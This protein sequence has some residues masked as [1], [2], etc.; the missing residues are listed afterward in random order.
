MKIFNF[1]IFSETSKELKNI[2]FA[3][4]KYLFLFII[5]S[6]IS[7]LLEFYCVS[8]IFNELEILNSLKNIEPFSIILLWTN[9]VF[10]SISRIVSSKV[11]VISG[12]K[13]SSSYASSVVKDIIYKS[14]LWH[15]NRD[16]NIIINALTQQQS[17][18][19]ST[20]VRPV[21]QALLSLFSSIALIIAMFMKFGNR[22]ILFLFFIAVLYLLSLLSVRKRIEKYS[23]NQAGKEDK[24]MSII[25]DAMTSIRDIF[26]NDRRTQ[27]IKN[28]NLSTLEY[29]DL[30]GK[31]HFLSSLPKLLLDVIVLFGI[32]I[33]ISFS[34]ELNSILNFS[35]II[36][37][38]L[39]FQRLLPNIISLG[40]VFN[41]ISAGKGSLLAVSKLRNEA[42]YKDKILKNKIVHKH[43]KDYSSFLQWKKIK[44]S[45]YERC[46]TKKKYSKSLIN[47]Y[48][49]NGIS[50][51]SGSGKT[52]LVD[53][54][55]GL[56]PLNLSNEYN[57]S[58]TIDDVKQEKFIQKS[59]Y[60]NIYYITQDTYLERETIQESLINGLENKLDIKKIL[61]L[62]CLNKYTSSYKN[63]LTSDLSGG[64][65][66][67]LAIAKA[68]VSR[69]EIIVMDE[70]TNGLD[71]EIKK[72]ILNNLYYWKKENNLTYIV[73]SHDEDVLNWCD[74][75][76]CL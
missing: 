25:V 55:C 50:G 69:K 63:K 16:K 14:F 19:L 38:G 1:K 7:S 12:S 9:I 51:F 8:F 70:I 24:R 58:I 5:V 37:F 30:G 39:S 74:N 11:I 6:L 45:N 3:N 20:F 61:K 59:F 22:T 62:T 21:F 18:S 64:E 15:R 31:I 46:W 68:L 56:L 48:Q 66:K 42:L 34:S 75:V 60:S 57:A 33:M 32:G 4:K 67:R 73:I 40:S 54:L 47:R 72:V 13:I 36:S 10:L 52:T 17:Y 27:I 43:L 41:S 28:Y 35:Y 23:I 29:W 49:I 44:I 26:V 53:I 71:N 65:K 76:I 2:F